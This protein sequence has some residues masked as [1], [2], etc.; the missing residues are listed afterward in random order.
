MFR[1]SFQ[2]NLMFVILCF[3]VTGCSEAALT[4]TPTIAPVASP[5]QEETITLTLAVAD[6]PGVPSTPYVLEFIEQVKRLSNGKMIVKPLWRGGDVVGGDALDIDYEVGVIRRVMMGGADLGFAA[7]RSWDTE[8]ITSFQALQAPFLIDNDA[9]AK[10]VATSDI[11]TQ[12]LDDLS[13]AGVVGLTLWP[14]DLRHPFSRVP[15]KP[16]LSPEDFAGLNIRETESEVTIR[17]I[18]ALGGIPGWEGNDYQGAESGLRQG[19]SLIGKPTA[20]GNITFFAK[21]QVLVAKGA[22][23]E[24]LNEKQR[25]VLRE[26]AEAAQ[27]KA[28]AE[29]M[30]EFDAASAWCADGGTIVMASDKQVAAFEQAAQPVYDWIEQD[31]LNAE[32]I[33]AIRALKADTEPSPGAEACSPVVAQQDSEPDKSPEVWTEGLPPNGIWQVE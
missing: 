6:E 8:N 21:F 23:F 15:D 28:I 19:Y 9:L 14:E 18:E 3:L 25:A 17:L 10:A 20:T 16:L 22:T 31:S 1:K 33:A 32:L 7:S 29:H 30:S 27:R 5:A 13:L 4:S 24:K 2:K 26:A 11:A 12:M